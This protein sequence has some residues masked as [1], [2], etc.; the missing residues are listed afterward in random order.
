[1]VENT[2]IEIV[3]Y[4][5]GGEKVY[6]YYKTFKNCNNLKFVYGLVVSGVTSL[7]EAFLGC[8]A[9]E[10][11]QEPLEFSSSNAIN[12]ANSFQFCQ[13][14]KNIRF[15]EQCIGKMAG[16]TLSFAYSPLLTAESV[17]SIING[18]ATIETAQTVTFHQNVK[19]L[20]SQV[21]SANAKGWTVAGGTVVSEE[22]YYG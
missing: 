19:I 16:T 3:D 15:A 7:M 17:Q 5:I 12:F 21:D 1:M 6:S 2:P 8:R 4:L 20:Q 11:I 22:E 10:T 13:A 18:L 9:L 14:L